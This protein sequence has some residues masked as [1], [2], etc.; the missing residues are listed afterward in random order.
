MLQICIV[1]LGHLPSQVLD[2]HSN[3]FSDSIQ[4]WCLQVQALQALYLLYLLGTF[5]TLFVEEKGLYAN[6][7]SRT[8]CKL[9]YNLTNSEQ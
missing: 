9:Q 7:D 6:R 2:C 5:L 1:R 3:A 4:R 8:R